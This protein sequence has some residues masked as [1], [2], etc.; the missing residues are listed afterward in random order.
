M[1]EDRQLVLPWR[2]ATGKART[3]LGLEDQRS[4]KHTLVWRGLEC[5]GGL[6]CDLQCT[7][8]P[9]EQDSLVME[10]RLV[11]FVVPG[12]DNDPADT[13]Y[14]RVKTHLVEYLGKASLEYEGE[15]GNL[16]S[17]SEW[18]S[19][20]VLV[21]WKILGLGPND[22]CRGELWCKPLPDDYLKL[23]LPA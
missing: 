14:S 5:L 20:E 3:V 8:L 21:V 12:N 23:T 2:C 9:K 4:S 7:F 15:E 13:V 19:E 1:I 10:L 11:E 6:K 17:F 16:R 18:E 22:S